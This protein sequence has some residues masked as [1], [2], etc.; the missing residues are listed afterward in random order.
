MDVEQKD[1]HGLARAGRGR[2]LAVLLGIGLGCG[3]T[4]A[5]AVTVSA[6]AWLDWSQFQVD[7]VSATGTLFED[8][9]DVYAE[10]VAPGGFLIG[11]DSDY[12]PDWATPIDAAVSYDDGTSQA[13]VS[14]AAAGSE[15]SAQVNFTSPLASYLFDQ[16]ESWANANRYG[17]I[18]VASGGLLMIT[19]P[20]SV[21]AATDD[22]DTFA[23]AWVSLDAYRESAPGV[24]AY[25]YSSAEAYAEWGY[26]PSP[27]DAGTLA[28][29]LSV[30]AGDIVH[31]YGEADVDAW[32]T[33]PVPLPPAVWLLGGG[34][35]L[36]LRRRV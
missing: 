13:A 14:A 4:T 1:R 18:E 35:A 6:T 8:S 2:T 11:D 27:S 15:L 36:L 5:R 28:L 33:A 26:A 34:V 3:T 10:M 29:A 30:E 19:V 24:Y 31:L 12:T 21:V 23:S 20:Y 22:A 16:G 9:S 17:T 7:F 32:V 25:S